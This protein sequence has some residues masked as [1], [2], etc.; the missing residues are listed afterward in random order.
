M[1][2]YD[3]IFAAEYDRRLGAEGYPGI[4]L[5]H[6]ERELG[7]A[8][9]VID[10]GAGTGFFTIPLAARGRYMEAIEPSLH[11]LD[12]LTSKLDDETASRVR[13]HQSTWEDWSGER[14]DA[15]ICLHSIY[16]MPD[17]GAAI[18]KMLLYADRRILLVRSDE[19]S[20]NLSGI[21]REKTGK[22]RNPVDLFEKIER[23]LCVLGV[24]YNA[25]PVEQ[26]RITSFGNLDDEAAYFCRH[27]GLA[28]DKIEDVRRIIDEHTVRRGDVR[29]FEGLYRDI[30]VVF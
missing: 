24:E 29:E 25:R 7:N 19:G 18:E 14:G 9:R 17:P 15:L 1:K 3:K 26:R 30:I 5:D 28:D 21:L 12:I 6:V 13:I 2:F 20:R 22:T 4:L 16:P 23:M 8:R 11:M 10:V 27:L